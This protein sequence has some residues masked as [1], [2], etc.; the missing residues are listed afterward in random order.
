MLLGQKLSWVSDSPYPT[1]CR[2]PHLKIATSKWLRLRT[3]SR[4][5]TIAISPESGQQWC[6]HSS[7]PACWC[8]TQ[9]PSSRSHHHHT[10]HSTQLQRGQRTCSIPLLHAWLLLA[11]QA[12]LLPFSKGQ[13][14]CSSLNKV[15]IS[16]SAWSHT[17][18]QVPSLPSHSPLQTFFKPSRRT[19]NSWDKSI[20]S[21]A[22]TQNRTAQG[23]RDGSRVKSTCY[24]GEDPDSI[25][26][27]HVRQITTCNSS[28]RGYNA[29][30]WL[31]QY[32]SSCVCTHTHLRFLKFL[33][34]S[35]KYR[36]YNSTYNNFE[37]LY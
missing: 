18:Q 35:E 15:K 13:T 33:F 34:F 12:L 28:S 7:T 1:V 26:R 32:L 5:Q 17:H 20:K 2:T 37:D 14:S 27:P 16:S 31:K 25:P 11:E 30:L 22:A 23:W 8:S 9:R 10:S 3:A 6:P 19:E 29:P 24:S 4:R 36:R 21:K